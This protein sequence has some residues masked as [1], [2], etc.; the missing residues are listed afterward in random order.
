[1]A[2]A[3]H[4]THPQKQGIADEGRR[5]DGRLLL[6]ILLNLAL[7]VGEA[8]AGFIAGSLAL[9]SDAAHNAGDV[10]G[11]AVTFTARKLGRKPP[12]AR[13]TYGLRRM[14]IIAA[15]A[16]GGFLLAVNTLIL[17]EA[18]ER[19]VN[20][21][22][23]VPGLMLIVASIAI[24]VN[25]LGVLLLY[26][27][28][29]EDI[30]LR[31]AFLHLLQDTLASVVVVVAALLAQAGVGSWVD[32]AA[33]ILIVLLVLRSAFG[34]VREALGV[35]LEGAPAGVDITALERDVHERFPTVLLHH[36]HLW[37]VGPGETALT[38]HIRVPDMSVE[39]AQVLA[40]AIRAH[41]LEHFAVRHATLEMEC[42]DCENGHL[43]CQ[44]HPRG[45]VR[46]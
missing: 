15:L 24:A 5:A 28:S 35:L 39:E 2:H 27:H 17:R 30:N 31:S 16:N 26:R 12:S 41:L 34:I 42:A 6:T 21:V 3:H 7:T 45:E 44:G 11:L 46:P 23:L 1:M 33:S 18:A 4:P 37:T 20:P 38:A 19:L 9:L 40:G 13:F 32:P 29:R 43:L 25:G 36:A 14:E 22:P 10:A 8:V